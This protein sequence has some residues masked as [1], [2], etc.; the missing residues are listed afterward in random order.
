[1]FCLL[2]EGSG[3]DLAAGGQGVVQEVV[4]HVG[5]ETKALPGGF[6]QALWRRAVDRGHAPQCRRRPAYG[7]PLRSYRTRVEL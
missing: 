5:V 7:L 6:R 2:E 1:V 3:R 4:V